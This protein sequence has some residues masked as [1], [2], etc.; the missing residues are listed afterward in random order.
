LLR[1]LKISEIEKDDYIPKSRNKILVKVLGQLRIMD[2]RGTGFLRIRETM[3]KWNMPSPKFREK[4][5]SFVIRFVNPLVRKIPE[6]DESG[7]NERQK[8]AV[9]YVRVK[10]RITTKE[11]AAMNHISER[12]ARNDLMRLVNNKILQKIGK[13]QSVYYV[14]RQSFSKE[15]RYKKCLVIILISLILENY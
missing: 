13:T 6:I 4:M 1:P 5:D 8:K 12:T 10:S 11:Y 9:E 2:K 15:R 3:K 7:L 14:I